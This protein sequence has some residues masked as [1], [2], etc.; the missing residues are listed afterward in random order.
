MLRDRTYI[1][2][3]TV[4]VILACGLSVFGISSSEYRSN[5]E[6]V[7]EV[8][9]EMRRDI[10]EMGNGG[11]PEGFD[12][13]KIQRI[14]EMLP[15][16]MTVSTSSDEVT[17]S[18]RWLHTDLDAFLTESD[19]DRRLTILGG[20]DERLTALAWQL[21]EYENAQ[22]SERSKD[23]DKQKLAEILQREQFQKP[24]GEQKSLIER[25]IDRILEWLTGLFPRP[26]GGPQISASPGLA[27]LMQIAVILLVTAL[28]LFTVYKL[29]PHIFPSL[30]RSK[31]DV[32]GERV[33]L[34][35]T[36]EKDRTPND[37]LREAELLFQQGDN[38]GAIRKGYIALLFELS[39]RGA[40]GLARHKTNRDY[41]RDVRK[42]EAL[43]TPMSGLTGVFEKAWYGSQAVGPEAWHYFKE[44]YLAMLKDH[45]RMDR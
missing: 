12:P 27:R 2:T 20:I 44:G 45:R 3:A 18:N 10:Y 34:G 42:Q 29:A 22:A 40:V 30:R 33:I 11:P 17:V 4:A 14:R 8:V 6:K 35:E 37:L 7:S 9:D 38:R 26:S 15:A 19:P 36:I 41:L 39:E 21:A 24:S 28:V 13:G 5:I 25:W 31:K 43:F 32:D 1:I 23:E 16:Q